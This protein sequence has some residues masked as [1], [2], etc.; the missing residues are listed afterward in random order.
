MKVILLTDVKALG[1]KGAIVEVA[2]GYG[3]NFLLPRKLATEASKGALTMLDEQKKAHAKREAAQLVE[4]QELA[5]LLESKPVAVRA[6]AGGN[7]KLFGAVTNADIADAITQV[8]SIAVD[9]HKI[10]VKNSIKALG[11]YPI[12]I[13][14]GKNVVAKTTV[15]VVAA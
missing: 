11:T 12:E 1:K 10:D 8:F 6:K 2:E 5:K 9:K 14:L 15:N 4:T 7:G 3:R 13:R